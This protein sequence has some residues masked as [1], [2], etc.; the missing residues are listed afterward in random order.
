MLGQTAGFSQKL[1]VN[2]VSL[3][4]STNNMGIWLVD[5]TVTPSSERPRLA[6]ISAHLE[7]D[8]STVPLEARLWSRR[9]AGLDWLQEPSMPA[10]V[11]AGMHNTIDGE[12]AHSMLNALQNATLRLAPLEKIGSIHPT[13]YRLQIQSGYQSVQ[14]D[15]SGALPPELYSLSEFVQILEALGQQY[16]TDD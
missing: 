8:E 7:L 11:R 6:G 16:A 12:L 1:T 3:S 2:N 4:S 10:F 5:F 13:Q 14:L 15:W 9:H